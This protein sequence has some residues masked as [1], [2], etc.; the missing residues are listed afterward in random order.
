M[1]KEHFQ[2]SV[3]EKT[4]LWF[5][6]RRILPC[7]YRENVSKLNDSMTDYCKQIFLSFQPGNT[8]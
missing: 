6:K 7:Y 2:I 5:T 3:T 1:K 8:L 4:E